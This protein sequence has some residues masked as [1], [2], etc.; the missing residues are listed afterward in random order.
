MKP[1]LTDLSRPWRDP[2][3]TV[4]TK[5]VPLSSGKTEY[6]GLIY[7]WNTSSMLGSY[8]DFPGHIRETDD[9]VRADNADPADFWRM[10]CSV[11]RL[12]RASGS[13]EI[14][15]KELEEAFGGR[16]SDRALILNALGRRDAFD[17]ERRTVW[18][19]ENALDWII[20]CG[21]TCLVSDVYES[22]ELLGVFLK[23]F[24]AGVS[25]VCE[26]FGLDSL[27]EKRVLLSIVFMPVPGVTQLPCRILAEPFTSTDATESRRN[28][29]C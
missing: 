22:R 9:G 12:D 15:A 29:S 25:A 17:I 2:N 5:D 11:I 20:G 19:G 1:K 18:L 10:P 14:T 16:P 21:V 4:H 28:I 27:T 3:L 8:I 24:R 6:T 26:P 13:G 7:S 23:L